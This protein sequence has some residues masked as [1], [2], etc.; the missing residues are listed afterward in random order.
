MVW[1][2][3]RVGFDSGL[4]G[5]KRGGPVRS[6]TGSSGAECGSG[7]AR[8]ASRAW[9]PWRFGPGG[10]AR[11]VVSVGADR[12]RLNGVPWLSPMR[13]GRLACLL[14]LPPGS[15]YGLRKWDRRCL[16]GLCAASD[17]AR[18]GQPGDR[19]GGDTMTMTDKTR[20]ALRATV[21]WALG[22]N[23]RVNEVCSAGGLTS[24]AEGSDSIMVAGSPGRRV[25]GSPGRRV[26]GSPGR[27]VAGSPGRRVAGSPGR[28]TCVFPMGPLSPASLPA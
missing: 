22:L 20:D 10:D 2:R 8:S 17:E 15:V 21:A 13:E 14:A 24:A 12:G 23:G 9:A 4:C 19:F 28:P 27:R 3:L 6:S 16:A 26:A 1:R 11:S 18:D 7:A 25:A 5:R